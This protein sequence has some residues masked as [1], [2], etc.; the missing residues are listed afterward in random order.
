[1]RWR[2]RLRMLNRRRRDGG[3]L[4]A[5]TLEHAKQGIAMIRLW[6][7]HTHACKLLR[8][9]DWARLLHISL[10][11]YVLWS[12]RSGPRRRI[13]VGWHSELA[14]LRLNGMCSLLRLLVLRQS[15]LLLTIRDLRLPLVL[16]GCHS[17]RTL[18]GVEKS[19]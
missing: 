9:D 18:E 6:R 2:L 8:T 14:E 12:L 17:G 13:G 11:M 4:S 3:G 10:L 19:H 15:L 16:V 5:G 1:M 7:V